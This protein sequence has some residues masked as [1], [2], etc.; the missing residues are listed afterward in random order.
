M[1]ECKKPAVRNRFR[2]LDCAAD[3]HRRIAG[4]RFGG[5]SGGVSRRIVNHD[6]PADGK[7]FRCADVFHK[8]AASFSGSVV[9][10][11]VEFRQRSQSPP[12]PGHLAPSNIP[13]VG[14]AIAALHSTT[15]LHADSHTGFHVD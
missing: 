8:N 10:H 15:A 2:S 3:V 9:S 13:A 5:D 11:P 6:R 1:K 12:Y 7:I 4:P 14:L